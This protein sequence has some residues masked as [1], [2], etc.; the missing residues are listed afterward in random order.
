MSCLNDGLLVATGSTPGRGSLHPQPGTAGYGRGGV[1]PT[2]AARSPCGLKDEYRDEIRTSIQD[3]L[4]QFTLE[5]DAYWQ[6]VRDLGLEIWQDWHRRE[7]F[8]TEVPPPRR[9]APGRT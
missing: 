5:D 9:A 6:G 8:E 4:D 3:L 7:L 1:L 2:T